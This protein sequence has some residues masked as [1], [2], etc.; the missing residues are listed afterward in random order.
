MDFQIGDRVVCVRSYGNVEVG[1]TGTYVHKKTLP[2]DHGVCWDKYHDNRHSCS[3]HCDNKHG[4]YVD[5]R[6]IELDTVTDLGDFSSDL[7]PGSVL[8]LFGR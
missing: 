6:C 7:V 5:R 3:K 1:E 8:D 2:P 4:Y